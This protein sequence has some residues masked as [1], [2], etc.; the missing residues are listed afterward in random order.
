MFANHFYHK[1]TRK[2]VIL[3]G[4]LFNGI[5]VRRTNSETGE[6]IERVRVP[7]TYGPK[8]KYYTRL[9]NDPDLNRPIQVVLPRMS[10]EIVGY[11]YD[12]TRAQN[13]LLQYRKANTS[14][15]GTS[16]YMHVPYDLSFELQVYSRNTDDGTQIIEQIL[17]YFSPSYAVSIDPVPE[18]GTIKDIQV[19]LNSVSNNIEYE[20]N[21]D[22]VRYVVWTLNF[23]MKAH[24]FGPVLNPK[25]IRKVYTNI[26][27]YP[28]ASGSIVR[29]NTNQGN[30]GTFTIDDIVYQGDKYETA[31][32]YGIV[33]SW[34]PGT[35]RI[36]ITGAQGTFKM[37]A[38]IK[39]VSTNAS[40][41]VA[42]FDATPITFAQITIEPDPLTADPGDDYGYT[43]TI[44]E[45]P[46]TQ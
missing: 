29:I 31:S 4:N 26:K 37:N 17:P 6:E 9:R 30:S 15:G 46:N 3:F 34:N 5:D 35:G 33:D 40:Y 19:I 22:S 1:L 2:Y 14:T 11:S 28:M 43:T 27:N 10:F 25:I 7:I 44:T 24:Y 20:G 39:A 16:Q 45:W 8:E 13:R 38:A 36:T 23:T 41:N 32:A 18:L 12:S 42:S 21:F